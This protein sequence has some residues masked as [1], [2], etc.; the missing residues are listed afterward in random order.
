MVGKEGEISTT[1]MVSG[2]AIEAVGGVEGIIGLVGLNFPVVA[3]GG[4]VW[5]LG[6]WVKNYGK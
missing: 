5:L 1:R 2:T 3:A 6:N 4:L